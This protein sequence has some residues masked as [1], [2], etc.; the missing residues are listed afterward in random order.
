MDI[1][2]IAQ[3]AWIGWLVLIGLFLVIEMFTLEFTCLML[4]LGSVVGFGANLLGA[5]LWLQL[6]L[7]AVA[8]LLLLLTL[9]PPLLRRL[10]KS[11]DRTKSNVEALIG[12]RGV[13]VQSTDQATGQVKLAN[14]DI[15]SARSHTAAL[16]PQTPVIVAAISGAIAE[17]EPFHRE[18][19]IS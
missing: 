6:I 2:V 3:F 4:A 10:G 5:P 15:W 13:I 11:G 12:M 18:G 7:A 1:T 19:G 16:P 14:G 17:V 8:A 9:R